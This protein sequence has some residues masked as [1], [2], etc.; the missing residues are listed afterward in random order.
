MTT[1]KERAQK[2]LN[3]YSHID[4]LRPFFDVEPKDV[5]NRLMYSLVPIKNNVSY[6]F[7][8]FNFKGR[9]S[10]AK[11]IYIHYSH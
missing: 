2:A 5:L 6:T 8:R 1:G 11:L 10:S 3:I 7:A 4:F 9:I